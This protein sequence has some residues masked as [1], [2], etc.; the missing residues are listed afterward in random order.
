[1]NSCPRIQPELFMELACKT[2][3][4]RLTWIIHEAPLLDRKG[5]VKTVPFQSSKK[6]PKLPGITELKPG[7]HG[8]RLARSCPVAHHSS[9]RLIE[10][11]RDLFPLL[12]HLP[13]PVAAPLNQFG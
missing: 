11:Q 7:Y 12:H 10:G 6:I 9:S 3:R 1:M 13:K 2:G 4:A 8:V 5:T